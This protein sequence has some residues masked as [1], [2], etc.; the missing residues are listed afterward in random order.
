[1]SAGPARSRASAGIACIAL[2]IFT[3][4]G[5][6]L[7]GTRS[8]WIIARG[9]E[10]ADALGWGDDVDKVAD[11]EPERVDGARGLFARQCLEL[12]EGVLDRVEVRAVGRLVAQPGV[13]QDR[14]G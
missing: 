8:F 3:R 13:P 9:G 11:G 10:H 2:R 12:G 7:S 6:S 1:M 5:A 14:A 4:P